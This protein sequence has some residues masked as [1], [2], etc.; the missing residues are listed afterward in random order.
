MSKTDWADAYKHIEVRQED[1]N[2]QWFQ[3]GGQFF[4]EERLI[5][6][7]ASS[8]GI[9][10][11]AAKVILGIVCHEANF[12]AKATCQHLDDIVAAHRDRQ[13]VMEFDKQFQAV[14]DRCGVKLAP[15]D[16]P[17]KAFPASRAGIIF[18]V[19]YNTKNWTWS[20]PQK[21]LVN[22]LNTAHDALMAQQLPAKNIKSLVGK[23]L[24]IKSL[25]PTA[26]FNMD[27]IM[28]ILADSNRQEVVAID[29]AFKRQLAFWMVMLRACSVGLTIP[30]PGAAPPPWAVNIFTDAGGGTLE[31]I[32]RGCGGVWGTKWFYLQWSSQY[33]AA[34]I[35]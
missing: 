32:G 30:D 17:E 23:L 27:Q 31:A 18:G 3:W 20:I 22:I 34:D 24:H 9:F 11:G 35:R 4:R 25:V 28:R 10:D 19:S 14:A 8:A 6:G 12:P 21:K 13:R 16:N 29:E 7:S 15:K 33:V 26:K 2:L 1:K 5:F